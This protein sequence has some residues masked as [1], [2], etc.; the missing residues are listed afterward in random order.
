MF[1]KMVSLTLVCCLMLPMTG[2]SGTTSLTTS[3]TKVTQTQVKVLTEAQKKELAK[4]EKERLAKLEKE[5]LAKLEKEIYAKLQK[6]F[7]EKEN[8]AKLEKERLE[9]ERVE[10]EKANAIKLSPSYFVTQ[11]FKS[12]DGLLLTADYYQPQNNKASD[13]LIITFHRAGWSRGEYRDIG[14]FLAANNHAVL[15]VDMR[16][17]S[18]INGVTNET[19]TLAAE[20]KL[21]QNHPDALVDMEA[22]IEY[23][24]KNLGYKKVVLW[25]S[26]YSSCLSFASASKYKDVVQGVIAFSP[27]EYFEVE[28]KTIAEHASKVNMPVMVVT[29]PFEK[30]DSEPIFNALSKNNAKNQ[31]VVIGADNLHGSSML[32]NNITLPV[33]KDLWGKVLGFIGTLGI[34]ITDKTAAK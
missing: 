14:S 9:Q 5:L 21:P 18:F 10:K 7:L 25:G 23:A 20:K 29:A 13:T 34:Q 17:G 22:T 12:G 31:F 6:E 11:Q 3:G 1:R 19:A 27:G 24:T 28:K 2:F 16:S 30:V 26:S 15:A 33:R 8:L 4:K 32:W